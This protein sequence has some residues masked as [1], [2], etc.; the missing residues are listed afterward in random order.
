[1]TE[2]EIELCLKEAKADIVGFRKGETIFNQGDTPR[3]ITMLVEGSVSIGN[4]SVNGKRS[5]MGMFLLSI[6]G[7]IS[8]QYGDAILL[9]C[10]LLFALQIITVG[11]FVKKVDV[12]DLSIFQ[13]FVVACF[14]SVVMI[15]VEKPPVDMIMKALPALLY[16]GVLS[17]ACGYTLQNVGQLYVRPSIA[18]LLMSLESVFSAIFAWI[19]LGEVLGGRE[20]IGAIMMFVAI[21]VAQLPTKG[22]E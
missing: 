8:L 1:M 18:S 5:I 21:I 3:Y 6:L 10:A 7:G 16:V 12:L 15:V 13:F 19:I 20:L 9:F 14:S 17:G 11:H 4:D 2:E 22:D